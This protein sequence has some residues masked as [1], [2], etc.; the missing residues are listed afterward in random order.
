VTGERRLVRAG[1]AWHVFAYFPCNA[2]GVR[3]AV[4]RSP[5]GAERF[6]RAFARRNRV[7]TSWR[8]GRAP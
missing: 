8:I 7:E 2:A 5:R 3:V 1:H 6:A 4:R